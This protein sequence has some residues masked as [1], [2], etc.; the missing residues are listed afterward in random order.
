MKRA[1]YI[2]GNR[3]G[4]APD[5][6]ESRTMTVGELIDA[7]GE[8]ANAYGEDALVFLRND[9]GYTYGHFCYEDITEGGFDSENVFIG[10]EEVEEAEHAEAECFADAESMWLGAGWYTVGSV[11][12]EDEKPAWYDTLDALA[13][14]YYEAWSVTRSD[15]AFIEFNG[16]GDEPSGE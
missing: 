16:N 5:Q 8:F 3:S 12:R 15:E 7:L 9:N 2:E 6:C 14:A 11:W 1:I 4:Y 10:L 13:A